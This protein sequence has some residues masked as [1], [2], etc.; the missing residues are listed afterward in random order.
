MKRL[1]IFLLF[2]AACGQSQPAAAPPHAKLEMRTLEAADAR[3][4]VLD[5]PPELTDEAPPPKPHDAVAAQNQIPLTEADEQL[6][7]RMP[8][9]PAIGLDPVDGSKISIRADTPMFELKNHIYYFSSE[10]NKR[11]FMATPQQFAKGIFAAH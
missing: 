11:T 4:A 8:F 2:A 6:R 10:A 7:A 5:P 9:A 1:A 3:P